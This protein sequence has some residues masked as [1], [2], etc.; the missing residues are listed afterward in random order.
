MRLDSITVWRWLRG[1]I[2]RLAARAKHFLKTGTR[3]ARRASECHPRFTRWRVVLVSTDAAQ[4]EKVICPVGGRT[5]P[6]FL[7]SNGDLC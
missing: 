2:R 4:F 3:Q 6:D 7:I 1:V 5:R